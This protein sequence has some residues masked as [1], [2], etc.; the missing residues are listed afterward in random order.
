MKLLI[1]GGVAG[2]AAAAAR[3]RR[4]DEAANIIMLERGEYVSFA[5]CGLPYYMGEV[6]KERDKLLVQSPKGLKNRFNIDVRVKNRA[7]SIDLKKKEVTVKD[8]SNGKTYLESYDYLIL[9]PGA[10]PIRPKFQGSSLDCVHTVRTIA[11]IEAVKE[12]ID[13]K[14][15]KKAVVIGAGF[16]GLEIAENL[17]ERGVE[18]CLVE[19][20]GQL[21]PPLD[22]EMAVILEREIIAHDVRLFLNEEVVSIE[23]DGIGCK[24]NTSSGKKIDTDIVIM[25][26][27]VSP[28][29]QLAEKAGLKIAH[30]GISVDNRMRTSNESVFAIGDAVEV[31]DPVLGNV[32]HV[33]LAG[34]AAKQAL[35]AVHNIFGIDDEYQGSIGTAIVKVFNKT[36]A[37]TG[38]N[39]KS[40]KEKNKVYNKVYTFPADHVGYYPGASAMALKLLYEPE[41]GIILGAQAIGKKGIDRK[42][43]V[44]AVAVKQ[45]LTIRDLSELELCYA[46]PYGTSKDA[47]NLAA[48]VALNH[49]RGLTELVHWENITR[50]NFL[51]DVRTPEE[52][53]KGNVPNSIHIPVDELRPRLKE[54]PK[55]KKIFVFCQVG[56]RGHIACR[57]LI[58]SGYD[59]ANISGG[60][61]S[62]INYRDAF[63]SSKIIASQMELDSEIFCTGPTG[64]GNQG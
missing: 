35:V 37:M 12:K 24:V 21:M 53:K 44:L 56:I 14:K 32:R 62:F 27:G 30:K 45:R 28:E 18:T 1:V 41:T 6:I 15:A 4:L 59:C 23:D 17:R 54:L 34:P 49:T 60:Y 5:N 47:I 61:L 22:K 10:E 48:M 52:V 42:I 25:A 7:E 20:T 43:D 64:E 63:S 26:I 33:P 36:A 16:I 11:D 2:G 55:A 40:L 29:I 8:L 57:M 38:A 51:L 13:T 58:Q 39:E 50:E 46:P 19:K 31:K 3:A 9:S